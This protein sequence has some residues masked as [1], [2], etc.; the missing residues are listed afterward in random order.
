MI[1]RGEYGRRAVAGKRTLIFTVLACIGCWLAGYIGCVGFPVVPSTY[2]TP[3]WKMI[4]L[5]ASTKEIA[6]LLGLFLLF[7]ASLLIHRAS[8]VLSLVREKT[9]FPFL[10]FMLFMSTNPDSFPLNP[11]SFGVFFLVLGMY[12]LFLSYHEDNARKRAFDWAF[13]VSIGSLFWVDIVWFIPLFWFGMYHLRSLNLRSFLASVFGLGIVYWI[14][15]GW[16]AWQND[17]ELFSQSFQALSKFG[18][19]DVAEDPWKLASVGYTVVLVLVASFNILVQKHADSLRTREYLSFL[20]VFALWSFM[21]YLLYA[22]SS[23]GFLAA[24]FIPA[25]ILISHFFT[26][27]WN[28]WV[29]WIF[30]ISILFFI[31]I[32]FIRLWSNY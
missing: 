7:S 23:E 5:L 32:L 11:T 6:Y 13:F 10:F 26:V 17:F 21:L 30:Y 12:R 24:F 20:I 27:S 22:S 18:F 16:C 25:T 15:L 2:A 14:T 4:C 19:L 1:K 29:G 31:S 9:V 28:R 8:Y 3:L